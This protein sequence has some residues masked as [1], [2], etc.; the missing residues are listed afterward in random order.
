[1]FIAYSLAT[2]QAVCFLGLAKGLF[3]SLLLHY[4]LFGTRRLTGICPPLYFVFSALIYTYL[5]SHNFV[6]LGH[7]PALILL[8]FKA[9]K[10]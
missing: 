2:S 9:I 5:K 1:V 7:F 10:I 8:I 6:I 4:N 3:P